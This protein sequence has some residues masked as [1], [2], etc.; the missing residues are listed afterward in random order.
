HFKS[1]TLDIT[2]DANG[3]DYALESAI[4]NLCMKAESA[5]R[6]GVNI[7]ILSDRKMSKDRAP[8]PSLLAVGA[9]HHYLI[10]H[11]LRVRTGLLVEAGD[12]RETHHYATLLG[13]G[14]SAINPYLTFETLQ[15]LKTKDVFK[16]KMSDDELFENYI[17]AINYGL[18]KIFSKMGISTVQ[19][20]QGAQI[21]EILG[22][23]RRVVDKCFSRTVSRIEGIGFEGIAKETLIRHRLAYPEKPIANQKLEVGGVYQWKRRGEHHLFNPETIH[24]LQQSTRKSDFQ[25]FKKYT[26][27]INDQAR[28]AATLRGL[29]EFDYSKRKPIPI[30]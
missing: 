5:V 25:L 16:N 28:K 13:F 18:L 20:Y 6:Y 17:H 19:S 9:V 12:I 24:L 2:F 7:L 3:G 27:K 22:L 11:K 23:S 21:F 14:A 8:I 29:L 15:E 4:N 30:E 1:K 26:E 10:R